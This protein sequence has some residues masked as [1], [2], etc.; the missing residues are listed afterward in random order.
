M[1][2]SFRPNVAKTSQHDVVWDKY[3]EFDN[4]EFVIEITDEASGLKGFIAV[5]SRTLGIAHGGTRMRPY[6]TDS[7]ALKDVLNLSRAMSYKS[8]LAGLPY[9]GAKAVIIEQP[10]T[11]K[12][13]VL[14][15]YAKK[16]DALGGLF[17]TGTDVG[18]TDEDVKLM[19]Q[20]SK[21][22]LGVSTADTGGFSTSKAAALG[23][24]YAI[25]AAVKHKYG[26]DDLTGKVIGVK[27]VGKLGGELVSLLAEDG[28]KL[29]VADANAQQVAELQ[30]K[31]AGLTVVPPEQIHMQQMDIYAPCAFGNEFTEETIGKLRCEIIAGGANNQLADATIGDQLFRQGILYIPDY[32][33]NAGGL[34]FVSE[35]LE[36]DGFQLGRLKQRLANITSTL[37]TVFTRVEAE[38]LPTHRV[39][40]KIAEERIRGMQT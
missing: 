28:A 36:A 1:K 22:M 14:A 12:Q 34:I 20:H 40:D 15:A 10:N 26:S 4:H 17:H 31:V 3:S 2:I 32:I 18:L 11:D 5:H 27:G 30:Q 25:K 13:A 38:H 6:E 39:A 24:F 35:E 37:E 9:G 33:A 8:A 29:L 19:A 7:A 21:Y 16:V 23:V